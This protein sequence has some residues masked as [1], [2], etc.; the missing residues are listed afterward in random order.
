MLAKETLWFDENDE[1]KETQACEYDAKVWDE[2]YFAN[3][4]G[5]ME[6]ENLHSINYDTFSNGIF[7]K[8][9]TDEIDWHKDN[10]WENEL[11]V[12]YFEDGIHNFNIDFKY[13]NFPFDKQTIS[14]EIVN[15]H[16]MSDGLLQVSDYSKLYLIDFQTKNSIPGWNI[17][18]NRIKYGTKKNP[19]SIEPS[20][21]VSLEIDIERESGYYL[22]K[23]IL[24]IIIILI[25]CWTSLWI[26][27]KELEAKLTITIVCLLSLIAYN[28]IID[29]EIPKLEYLTIIDWIILTSYFYAALPNILGIY[30]FTLFSNKQTKKLKK[31]ETFARKYGLVSYLI[32]VFAIIIFNVNLNPENASA[33]FS[34]VSAK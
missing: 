5:G 8:P 10:N 23:V 11:Y 13:H 24:P 20:A 32:I 15:G 31:Y 21:T 3:P 19:T 2:S 26:I 33:M 17:V 7:L 30:F 28:F 18:D 25:V 29:G 14:F 1:F 9:Y 4:M 27:P 22:Y 6:F 12:E 16:D 34:W